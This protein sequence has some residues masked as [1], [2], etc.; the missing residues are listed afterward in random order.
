MVG[1]AILAIA[2]QVVDPSCG[3]ENERFEA[4]TVILG[5]GRRELAKPLRENAD[6]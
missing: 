2:S 5:I 4:F 3:S 6:V 1:V